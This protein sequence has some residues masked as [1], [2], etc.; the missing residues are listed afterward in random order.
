MSNCKIDKNRQGTP[1]ED[2]ASILTNVYGYK[3]T[4]STDSDPNFCT[5]F[6]IRTS[7]GPHAQRSTSSVIANRKTINSGI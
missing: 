2:L 1:K 5:P 3:T 4:V 7:S 6:G